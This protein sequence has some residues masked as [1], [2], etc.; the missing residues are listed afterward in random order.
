[1][2]S[3]N[4]AIEL[5]ARHQVRVEGIPCFDEIAKSISDDPASKDPAVADPAFESLLEAAEKVGPEEAVV[6]E[7]QE[8]GAE[9][10]PKKK[11][12]VVIDFGRL[13]LH[14]KIRLATLGN[15]YCRSNL[16]RDS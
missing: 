8:D 13:K 15:S 10:E 14:Q 16:I 6:D 12:S 1:M 2:S 5:C 9:A 4:R 11:R 7:D 3:V